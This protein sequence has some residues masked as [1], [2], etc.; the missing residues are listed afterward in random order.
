[1]LVPWSTL[2]G[3][4]GLPFSCSSWCPLSKRLELCLALHTPCFF[5]S[6]FLTHLTELPGKGQCRRQSDSTWP[7]LQSVL[8]SLTEI[9]VLFSLLAEKFFCR[10][11]TKGGRIDSPNMEQIGDQKLKDFYAVEKPNSLTWLKR[12]NS[13]VCQATGKCKTFVKNGQ[14]QSHFEIE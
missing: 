2:S 7:W 5:Y 11:L 3:C 1:M 10:N 9:W 4:V 14:D 12:G 8:A 13:S 6:L